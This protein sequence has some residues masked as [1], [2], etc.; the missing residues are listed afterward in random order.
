MYV[1]QHYFQP[2]LHAFSIIKHGALDTLKTDVLQMAVKSVN[3]S[4][5]RHG[6]IPTLL[7]YATHPRLGFPAD[8]PQPFLFKR[9][10]AVRKATEELSKRYS[11]R[12]VIESLKCQHYLNVQPINDTCLGELVLVYRT[13]LQAWTAPFRLLAISGKWE[14]VQLHQAKSNFRTT[15]VK[16]YKISSLQFDS[17]RRLMHNVSKKTWFIFPAPFRPLRV[18]P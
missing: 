2:L 11:R 6:L 8:L 7:F 14:T 4:I 3:D 10:L 17:T 5:H 12:Q 1:V 16:P 9:A 18:I 13:S 15:D